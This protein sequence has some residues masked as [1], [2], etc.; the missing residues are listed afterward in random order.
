MDWLNLY[1]LFVL[2]AVLWSCKDQPRECWVF[3]KP[4]RED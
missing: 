2:C 3:Y 1:L 4:R